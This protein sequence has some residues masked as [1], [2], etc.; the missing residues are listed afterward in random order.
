MAPRLL[1]VAVV[2]LNFVINAMVAAR[3]AAKAA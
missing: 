1:G 2:Q 3:P